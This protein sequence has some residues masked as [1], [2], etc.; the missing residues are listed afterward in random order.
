MIDNQ[1]LATKIDRVI[2]A[3]EGIESALAAIVIQ[4]RTPESLQAALGPAPEP[5]ASVGWPWT[6]ATATQGFL[7]AR[8]L[9][10]D[11]TGYTPT[12]GPTGPRSP[13]RGGDDAN[14]RVDVPSGAPRV[15]P[16]GPT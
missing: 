5:R 15:A 8:W 2:A 10:R 9:R 7:A 6:P 12:P 1:E 13:I 11:G 16:F 14:A 4:S 3:L